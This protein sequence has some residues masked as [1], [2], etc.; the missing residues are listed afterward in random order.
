MAKD[1]TKFTG[2]NKLDMEARKYSWT[3]YDYFDSYRKNGWGKS[4]GRYYYPA[5]IAICCDKDEKMIRYI[6]REE[7][8]QI[9][10]R[11]MC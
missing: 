4:F 1:N 5:M 9:S 11:S 6:Y 7:P 3:V 10:Y 8:E 2:K